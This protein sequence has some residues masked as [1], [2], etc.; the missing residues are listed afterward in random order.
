VVRS[1]PY[2]WGAPP[3]GGRAPR[4]GEELPLLVEELLTMKSFPY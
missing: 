4:S 2:W 1:S 3:T